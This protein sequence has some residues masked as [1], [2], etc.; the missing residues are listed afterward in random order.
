MISEVKNSKSFSIEVKG[1]N[2]NINLGDIKDFLEQCE[3]FMEISG[4]EFEIMTQSIA[5]SIIDSENSNIDPKQLKSQLR[6]LREV[7]FLLRNV[8]SND[9]Y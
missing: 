3:S 6:F 2:Y 8:V 4:V 1:V 5:D 9:N 7:G